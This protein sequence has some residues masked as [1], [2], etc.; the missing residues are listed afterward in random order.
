MAVRLPLAPARFRFFER[1]R[2]HNDF[3]VLSMVGARAAP[4]PTGAGDSVRIALGGV[5]DRP[6]LAHRG[7]AAPGGPA[8]DDAAIDEAAQAGA[9]RRRPARRRARERGVSRATSCPSTCGALLR[10][11][12]DE[13]LHGRHASRSPSRSTGAV[14]RR[15][16]EGRTHAADFLRHELGPDRHARRLRAGR[17]RHVHRPRGRRGGQVLPDAGA[18]ARRPRGRDRREPGRGR[19]P[20][21]A[22]AGVQGGARA[23]VRLLHARLPDDGDRA[24]RARGAASRA[25]R[26]AR[27]CP[28]SCAAAPATRAS[29]TPSS[30]T[31]ERGARWLRLSSAPSAA[32]SPGASGRSVSR[33]EDDRLLRGEGRF[34]DDVDPA[35][36]LH[37]AV[38]RCPFPHA[39]IEA[40]DVARGARARGRA[41]TCSSAPTSGE[42]TRPI[43]VL[44][45][46][47]GAAG[48]CPTTPSHR[49]PREYE[50]QPVVSVAATSR[51]RR[52]GRDRA[53][54]RRLRPAA[55]R[56]RRRS[57]RSS[58]RP[59]SCTRTWYRPTCSPSNPQGMGD[60]GCGVRRRRDR[61]R[62]Q[63]FTINRVTGLPM[64]ARGT[65]AEWRAGAARADGAHLDADAAPGAQPARRTACASTRA[66]CA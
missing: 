26:S 14:H 22:A 20:V 28:A 30:A 61:R 33:K 37:M 7:G 52:R 64:E 58:R 50:G 46:V 5:N 12:R 49:A 31:S 35:H 53:D 36:G 3:A 66:E 38:G 60:S 55:A 34:T 17:V 47:P 21:A 59:R 48:A 44:R 10:E 27:S 18:P 15:R 2:K 6:V 51:R 40:L 25:R 32:C 29:S 45:P 9:R 13:R 63:R 11:L 23:P 16:V 57:R 4:T 24:R 43:N 41:S 65:V 54:R 56:D 39:R 62:R 19:R 8:W 1:G 42:R